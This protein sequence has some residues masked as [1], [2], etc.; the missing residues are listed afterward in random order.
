MANATC[1]QLIRVVV[2]RALRLN[3]TGAILSG[4]SSQYRHAAPIL[5]QF[6]PQVPERDRFEQVDGNGNTCALFI[7]PPRAVD[8]V[9]LALN[10]CQLDA[11]LEE[12]L[13]GGSVITEGDYGTVGYL[14]PTDETVNANGVSLESWSIAWNQR[15]RLLKAGLPAY[16]E[17]VFPLTRWQRGQTQM[18][19]G[20]SV[21][22][23]TG[24]GEVNSAF[25]TGL[26]T[27]PMPVTIGE[28][29]FAYWLDNTAPAGVCGYQAV[30]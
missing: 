18:Q 9:N 24:I 2:L 3:A 22:P 5:L 15:Q 23:L 4:A 14:A 6:E 16:W 25:G 29:A 17:H 19:N 28:S 13:C 20:I 11:E 26:P 7:G 21:I 1:G 12:M 8:S 30:P 10:L 27:D